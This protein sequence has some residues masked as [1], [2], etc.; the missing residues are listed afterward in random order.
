MAQAPP[1]DLDQLAAAF[2]VASVSD[3]TGRAARMLADTPEL[4]DYS[5]ATA[6][7]LG[8]ADRVR[9]A[10]ER[11]PAAAVQPDPDTGWTP[12][13]AVSAS[14]WHR[15]DP[16]RAAG[17][18]ATARLLLDA[19]ADPNARIGANG[20]SAGSSALHCAAASAS[21][22]YGNEAITR[23]LLERGAVVQDDDLYLAAFGGDDHGCLRAMLDH[24]GAADAEV[25]LSAPLSGGGELLATSMLLEAGAD[26]RRF[27]AEPGQ[28]SSAVYFAVQS[29]CS[30]ELVA[31]LLHYGADPRQ[32]G[33]DGRS[34][35]WLAAINGRDDLLGLLGGD[36]SDDV[37]DT[38]RFVAACMRADRAAAASRLTAD[39]HLIDTLAGAELAAVV[40]AAESGRISAVM[41]MLDVGFPVGARAP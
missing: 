34:P 23:L 2:C 15:L 10:I 1:G 37:G 32:P 41:L 35:A 39:P 8:D 22:G 36:D 14:R 27:A 19:G 26:P 6:L 33:P 17:L 25:A 11:D 21:A 31:L 29:G 30:A 9:D 16:G 5:L 40:R 20:R 13:H 12:L 24:A 7:L 28:P 3:R 38:A 4:A 18:L